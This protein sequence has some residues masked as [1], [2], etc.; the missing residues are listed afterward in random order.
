[1][2]KYKYCSFRRL[3]RRNKTKNF[4]SIFCRLPPH[5]PAENLRKEGKF[6]VLYRDRRVRSEYLELRKTLSVLYSKCEGCTAP[7][8]SGRGAQI[9]PSAV[10]NRFEQSKVIQHLSEA[11]MSER[12]HL[13]GFARE[14][15]PAA[16]FCQQAKPRGAV[17]EFAEWRR[18]EPKLFDFSFLVLYYSALLEPILNR[19]RTDRTPHP[20][21]SVAG[22][23]QKF[24]L[25]F[26]FSSAGGVGGADKKWKGNFWFC[27]AVTI[28][29]V[30]HNM[31]SLGIAIQHIR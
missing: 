29:K 6:L 13:R 12:S 3:K 10:Q 11:K 25:P 24:S 18:G 21:P 14:S 27:F 2:L 20:L 4:F 22:K 28:N 16:M 1:M 26:F 7:V 30:Y 17:C 23:T 15:K 19:K 9:S 8:R 31:Q 5:P